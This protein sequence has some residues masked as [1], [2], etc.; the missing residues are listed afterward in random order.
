MI[1]PQILS[2]VEASAMSPARQIAVMHTA[3]A[4]VSVL[5]ML[6]FTKGIAG[7]ARKI[8]PINEK[9]LRSAQKKLVYI[10]NLDVPVG[11][12]L[13]QVRLEMMRMAHMAADN[14]R[15]AIEA[16][17]ERDSEKIETV[18]D[19]EEVVD[20]LCHHVTSALVSVRTA[21]LSEQQLNQLGGMLRCASD[22]ER[23]SDHAENIAEYAESIIT[24]NYVF[25]GAGHEDMTELCEKASRAVDLA[26]EIYEDHKTGLIP[27]S[28]A[29]E[30]EVDELNRQCVERHIR[31][32]M[33]GVCD[34]RSGV[35]FTEMA[36]DLERAADHAHNVVKAVDGVEQA[37]G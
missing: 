32:M 31:R 24:H 34:P 27:E 35:V 18:K 22:F 14:L 16:F 13:A 36:S 2:A 29:L 20:Y 33:Q 30:E 37:V 6:P 17:F 3:M 7:I 12:K 23:V 1:F 10:T 28:N 21:S 15:L 8:I 25:S 9:E 5:V 4:I 26:I 11:V 19:T